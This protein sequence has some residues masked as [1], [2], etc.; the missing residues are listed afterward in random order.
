E[1]SIM[2][3]AGY[4]GAITVAARMAGRGVDIVVDRAAQEAGG[5]AV[6]GMGRFRF[7]RLDNQLGGRTGRRG[8]N[9][10]VRFILSL[11]DELFQNIPGVQRVRRL[12]QTDS[13]ALPGRQLSWGIRQT[14]SRNGDA[15]FASL[16]SWLEKN[17]LLDQIRD[18]YEQ[19]RYR[20]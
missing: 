2:R 16:A 8:E 17:R 7:R 6:I 10:D 18:E 3:R 14:Q 19:Q 4:T 20:L 13:S 9:G 15:A 5:L 12:V 11:D 1:A